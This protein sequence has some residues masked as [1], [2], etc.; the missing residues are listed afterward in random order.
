MR[1]K[2]FAVSLI[3]LSI[4]TFTGQGVFSLVHGQLIGTVCISDPLS[5]SCPV[6][7]LAVSALKGTQIQIAVNIQGSDPMNG[8]DIFVKAD[9][10]VLNAVGLDLTGS[11]LGTNIFTVSE[12]IGNTGFGC[13]SGQDGPGVVEVAA[14]SFTSTT[15]PTA[16]KL[17]SI[18][19]NVTSSAANVVVGFQAGCSGT[20]TTANYCVTIVNGGAIDR[21]TIQESTG[22]PGD[23]AISVD[24]PSTITRGMI[25]FGE[26]HVYSLAGFFGSMSLSLSASPARKT[27]PTVF[28]RSDSTV[29]LLPGTST[30]MLFVFETFP[31][32]PPGTYTVTVTGSSG[33]LS[34]S[35]ASNIKVIIH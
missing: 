20:S 35:G 7:P 16:G 6:L 13:N 18:T 24:L 21:E 10:T 4:L 28:L 2:V 30:R 9:P 26:L 32:T 22:I 11:V 1:G 14:V 8:F 25:V 31:T 15:S 33:L 27:G 19:Y 23:F 17:F 5:T 29:F 34:R 12:C 3:T